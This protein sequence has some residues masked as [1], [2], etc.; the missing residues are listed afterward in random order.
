[1]DNE[2]VTAKSLSW[3]YMIQGN[4]FARAYKDTLSDFPTWVKKENV[5]DGILI[6]K[7]LGPRLGIDE[8]EFGHEVYTI[9]HNKDAHGKKGAIVAIV[10][11]TDPETVAKALRKMP[12]KD[13][14]AVGLVSMDLSD[15]MR[16]IV[17]MA[18][19][20]AMVV[21]DCFH[22][23]K[24]GG[25]GIEELRMKYKREAVKDVNRQK[26]EF[27]KHLEQLAKQRK[28]YRNSRKKQGKKR[29]KGKRRGRKPMRL[30]TR[31]EPKRLSN[32]ETLVDAPRALRVRPIGRGG[33]GQ[34]AD[35]DLV[36]AA[37]LVDGFSEQQELV[38]GEARHERPEGVRSSHMDLSHP[39]ERPPGGIVA[40]QRSG[41]ALGQILCLA[42]K[43]IAF[44]GLA[45]P[46]S[47]PVI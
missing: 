44:G 8:S 32:G 20:N 3:T 34:R 28:Y 40:K 36:A 21:R 33:L 30:N 18:F 27:K 11:G 47:S 1:M 25:E 14:E 26:A 17:R 12:Q 16:S 13:R 43:S 31:F 42:G 22:V 29:C 35:A 38:G 5:D 37:P 15:S 23:M 6:A 24:R 39:P 9:L 4:T 7:N 10:K 45:V 46:E 2:P 19:P 41:W